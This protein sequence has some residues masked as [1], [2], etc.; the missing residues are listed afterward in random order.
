MAQI[1][2]FGLEWFG[3]WYKYDCERFGVLGNEEDGFLL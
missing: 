3:F 1:P 2:G